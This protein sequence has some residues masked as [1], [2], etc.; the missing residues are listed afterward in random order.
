MI[1]HFE[2]IHI[3]TYVW[4]NP[5]GFHVCCSFYF[6]LNLH[7]YSLIQEISQPGKSFTQHLIFRISLCYL[8]FF[9]SAPLYLEQLQICQASRAVC[10]LFSSAGFCF[11]PQCYWMCVFAL[12]YEVCC[13]C[14]IVE[15]LVF[16]SIPVL[17]ECC[18][19]R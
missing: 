19:Y 2:L 10:F 7:S 18:M 14:W 3:C 13:L 16:M 9:W 6:L 5:S 4:G 11:Y 12:Y 17:V 8:Y 1:K 15:L